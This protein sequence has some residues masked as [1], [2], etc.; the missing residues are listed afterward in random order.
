MKV[1]RYSKQGNEIMESYWLNDE[2]GKAKYEKFDLI[3]CKVLKR[4]IRKRTEEQILKEG[5][6]VV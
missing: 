6:K 3:R 2:T 1:T 4:S 5:Y